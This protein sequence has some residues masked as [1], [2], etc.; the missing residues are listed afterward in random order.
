MTFL[1]HLNVVIYDTVLWHHFYDTFFIFWKPKK[2]AKSSPKQVP[3]KLFFINI[4]ESLKNV[5]KNCNKK[6]MKKK[7]LKMPEFMTLSKLKY[8]TF[9]WHFMTCHIFFVP[10]SLNFS[11]FYYLLLNVIL[12]FSDWL[13]WFFLIFFLIPG[14]FIWIFFLNY[15]FMKFY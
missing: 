8:D 3:R 4:F 2:C 15:I 7:K 1:W 11:V 14:F 5:E 6:K 9:L 13:V 10:N 12:S